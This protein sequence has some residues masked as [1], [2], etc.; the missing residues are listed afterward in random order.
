MIPNLQPV[1]LI[2]L[3]SDSAFVFTFMRLFSAFSALSVVKVV[4]KEK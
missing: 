3:F 2:S 4:A 1:F